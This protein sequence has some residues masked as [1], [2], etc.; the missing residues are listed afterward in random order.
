MSEQTKTCNIVVNS[1]VEEIS[2]SGLSSEDLT[3]GYKSDID[4]TELVM[5]FAKLIDKGEP[6][7]IEMP[8]EEDDEKLSLVLATIN[9][10]AKAYNSSLKPTESNAA[11][12][13]SHSNE[14]EVPF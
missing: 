14:D 2:I 9:D 1:A 5:A 8:A 4:L 6:V 12:E 11:V 13:P 10:I 7:L 3:I